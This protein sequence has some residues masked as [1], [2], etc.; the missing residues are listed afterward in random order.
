[1]NF[2]K[3]SNKKA[4]TVGS[5]LEVRIQ[6]AHDYT[7]KEISSKIM[8]LVPH[9][10][11][12]NVQQEFLECMLEFVSPVCTCAFEITN[13]LQ[14]YIQVVSKL[15]KEQDFILATS[16][17]HSY[18]IDFLDAV[19]NKRYKKFSKE[20]GLLLKKFHIC[21]FH[22]HIGLSS[23]DEA[24]H[25]YNYMLDKLPL[26]LALSANSP[27]FDG[28]DTGLLSYRTQ[29]FNQLPRAG[30]PEYFDSFEDITNMYSNLKKA[31]II[32]SASDLWWD[33]RISPKFHTLEIRIC[34]A[35]NDFQRLEDLINFYQALCF[36]ALNQKI[37]KLPHQILKQNKWNATRHGLEGNYQNN[38][39]TCKSIKEYILELIDQMQEEKVFEKLNIKDEFI[40]RLK[41]RVH[42]KVQAQIQQ[43]IFAKTKDLQEVEKLGILI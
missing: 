40:T 28:Q 12:N 30:V 18:K 32:D 22:I 23:S 8:P 35:N 19:K 14:Q 42:K 7:L 9:D 5:E 27:F 41:N 11:K 26:F 13:Y 39:F 43:D 33:L 17:A 1:M 16:G 34:D 21:G 20:Y 10:L 24:L 2:K 37:E 15:G 4:F 25:V 31:G 36:Y 3:W 38:S 29:L 6:D